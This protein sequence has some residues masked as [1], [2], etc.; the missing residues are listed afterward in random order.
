MV[1]LRSQAWKG[2]HYEISNCSFPLI[3]EPAF[4]SP[5]SSKEGWVLIH[6]LIFTFCGQQKR[7]IR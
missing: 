5:L 4:F 7:C 1:V 6:N 2:S 3:A